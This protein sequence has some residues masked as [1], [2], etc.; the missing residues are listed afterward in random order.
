MNGDYLFWFRWPNNKIGACQW[1]VMKYEVDGSGQPKGHLVVR[2]WKNAWEYYVNGLPFSPPGVEN[3][4]PTGAVALGSATYMSK[5]GQARFSDLR[6]RKLTSEPPPP[7]TDPEGQVR[8]Y[9][10]SLRQHPELPS[11]YYLRGNAHTN[12]GHFEAAVAD[13]E[14]AKK[15]R[16]DMTDSVDSILGQAYENKGDYARASELYRRP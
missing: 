4:S 14:K 6:I 7:A 2:I 12:L 9:T 13:L 1:D 8:F 11:Y 16:P 5:S 15:L 3:F 10:E